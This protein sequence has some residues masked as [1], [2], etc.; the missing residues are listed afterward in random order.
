MDIIVFSTQ[1]DLQL[2]SE[3]P[4]SGCIVCLH[5]RRTHGISPFTVA[6]RLPHICF[7][8]HCFCAETFESAMG[9]DPFPVGLCRR[10]G[11][12]FEQNFLIIKNKRHDQ[13]WRP[14]CCCFWYAT[15]H[16]G[17]DCSLRPWSCLIMCYLYDIEVILFLF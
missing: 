14:Y 7:Y 1:Y 10:H 16:P 17:K 8:T 2:H 3:Q 6:T 15:N 13:V 4:A 11:Q 5:D 9:F 12:E